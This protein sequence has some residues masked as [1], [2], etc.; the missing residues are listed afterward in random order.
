MDKNQFDI[1]LQLVL[2]LYFH[3][4]SYIKFF[5]KNFQD[6]TKREKIISHLNQN[7]MEEIDELLVYFR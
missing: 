2:P 7:E 3:P 5:L 4:T 6:Q 1:S